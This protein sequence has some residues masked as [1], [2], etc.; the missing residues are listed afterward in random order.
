MTIFLIILQTAFFFKNKLTI[1]LEIM[2]GVNGVIIVAIVPSLYV[3]RARTLLKQQ[4]DSQKPL[5]RSS[6]QSPLLPYLIIVMGSV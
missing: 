2:A 1:I 5:F 4:A 3:I 6:F